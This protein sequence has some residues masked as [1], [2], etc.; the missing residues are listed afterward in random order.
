M[1]KVAACR[2]DCDSVI[3]R[4]RNAVG[5]C[6]FKCRNKVVALKFLCII[7]EFFKCRDYCAVKRKVTFNLAADFLNK[8]AVV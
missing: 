1:C 6:A 7:A 2:L 5:I 8:F 3:I 4:I